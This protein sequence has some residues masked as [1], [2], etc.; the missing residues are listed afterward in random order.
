MDVFLFLIT[1][2]P[3]AIYTFGL[4]LVVFYW[5]VVSVGL[6]DI[7]VLDLPEPETDLEFESDI[8]AEGLA[9]LLMKIGLNGVPLTVVLSLLILLG[10]LISYFASYLLM[11]IVP[12]NLLWFLV[13]TAILIGAWMLAIPITAI[14]IK[15]LRPLFSKAK[16]TTRAS[17]LGQVAV[18]RTSRV[19]EGFGEVDFN[20]GGAGL[21]L[22]A[23]ADTPNDFKRGDRVVLLE[24]LETDNAYRVIPERDFY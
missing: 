15:P 1:T 13:G 24:Y 9:G 2:Y 3:V 17:V 5:L 23:R 18:V 6:L 8:G 11:A 10:W 7:D 12:G 16:G 21:V 14:L 19:D 22:K 20:D 4:C